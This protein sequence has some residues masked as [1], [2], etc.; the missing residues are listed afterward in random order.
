MKFIQVKRPRS[1]IA[2]AVVLLALMPAL[3]PWRAVA[4]KSAEPVESKTI[5]ETPEPKQ[6]S[7]QELLGREIKI[8]QQQ[9]DVARRAQQYGRASNEDVAKAQRDLLHLQREYAMLEK[10]TV[11]ARQSMQDELKIVEQ[12][13]AEMAK[14]VENG[15]ASTEDKLKIDR[16]IL[17]LRRQLASLDAAQP[18]VTEHGAGAGDLS[19]MYYMSNPELMKRYFPQMYAMMMKNGT[20]GITNFVQSTNKRPKPA[21][22]IDDRMNRNPRIALRLKRTGVVRALNVKSGEHVLKTQPLFWLDEREAQIQLR[23]AEAQFGIT[24]ADIQLRKSE[25]ERA[26]EL[27][28]ERERGLKNSTLPEQERAN[29]DELH[30]LKM[31]RLGSE[32]ELA[33]IKLEQARLEFEGLTISAP[34][35]GYVGRLPFVGQTVSADFDV[36]FSPD[37]PKEESPK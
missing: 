21:E 8:V 6:N 26:R 14:R 4:Q 10:D 33:R 9:V 35:D 37:P 25:L 20:N 1:T 27:E 16:E 15:A 12:L 2:I 11:K 17:S 22:N 28:K 30:T 24:E 19:M 31:R 29:N 3:I 13:R 7:E 5:E 32:L 18:A 36:D 23:A 34:S